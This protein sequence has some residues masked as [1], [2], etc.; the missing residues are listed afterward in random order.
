MQIII[1][2]TPKGAK[3]AHFIAKEI[4]LAGVQ[5]YVTTVMEI[6]SFIERNGFL[7]EDT[8]IH[9]RTA[10][11]HKIY[12]LLNNLSEKGYRILN[13]PPTLQLTS[14]KFRTYLH[15]KEHGIAC[16]ESLKT[17]KEEAVSRI[18]EKLK[19]WGEIVVKPNVSKG[20]GEFCFK[21]HYQH[22]N[23]ET[24]ASIPTKELI[25]Q[26]FINY[27]RLNRI[28]VLGKKALRKAVFYDEP[29][30]G[31]KCS[32]CLNP[33]IKHHKSPPEDL[34][35]FAEDIAGKFNGEIFF[36]DIFT[37]PSGYVLN[38]I[39]TSCSFVIHER[40]SGENI[41]KHIAEYLIS[42]IKRV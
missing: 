22:S 20:Q 8:L 11:P 37:T 2:R 15:A 14:D 34:I 13:A 17:R 19:E 7:P 6:E 39:N 23:L 29:L 35:N 21:F 33:F 9:A 5:C 16:A 25:I 24:I 27:H 36:I 42:Q 40:I 3:Y 12:R 26:K 18:Q 41:S 32:V 31:W 10:N 38:E 30:E 1:L 4:N 28:I